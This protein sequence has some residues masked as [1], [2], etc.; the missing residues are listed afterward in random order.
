MFA[1]AFK[2]RL[3]KFQQV[4]WCELLDLVVLL[5]AETR[6]FYRV[7]VK[8]V[9]LTVAVEPSAVLFVPLV[10]KIAVLKAEV[11]TDVR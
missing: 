3:S 4:V 11:G 5:I 10:L 2:Q 7:G 8:Q 1:D 6:C 9:E